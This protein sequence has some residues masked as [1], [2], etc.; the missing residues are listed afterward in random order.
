[1]LIDR[2]KRNLDNDAAL[3][4]HRQQ[5]GAPPPNSPVTKV[6]NRLM[7]KML[8]ESTLSNILKDQSIRENLIIYIRQKH[9]YRE[10]FYLFSDDDQEVMLITKDD[11]AVPVARSYSDLL[12]DPRHVRYIIKTET[13]ADGAISVKINKL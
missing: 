12:M 7:V 6:M 13:A 9:T 8:T 10:D 3:E 4:K 1:M 2:S 11:K 5:L